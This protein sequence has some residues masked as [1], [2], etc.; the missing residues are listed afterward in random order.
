VLVDERPGQAKQHWYPRRTRP[1]IGSP[2]GGRPS[3]PGRPRDSGTRASSG[4]GGRVQPVQDG[5]PSA[6]ASDR[7]PGAHGGSRDKTRD[8]ETAG[9]RARPGCGSRSAG[10]DPVQRARHRMHRRGRARPA[11]RHQRRRTR[12]RPTHADSCRREGRPQ[13]SVPVRQRPQDQEVL[14]G[15]ICLTGSE[16]GETRVRAPRSTS[17]RRSPSTKTTKL[18][19]S[20]ETAS[21]RAKP[22]E[23]SPWPRRSSSVFQCSPGTSR[24][25]IMPWCLLHAISSSQVLGRHT[26]SGS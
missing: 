13:R 4:P 14:P 19:G 17:C 1:A 12:A 22:I 24:I 18:D 20:E 25:E 15:A 8:E 7:P 10:H 3:R 5:K 11:R 21:R 23:P 26:T 16:T 9:C 6:R 2:R